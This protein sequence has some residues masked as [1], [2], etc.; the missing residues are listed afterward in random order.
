MQAPFSG[1]P[2]T[3][4]GWR[5]DHSYSRLPDIFYT[6]TRPVPVANPGLFVFNRPLAVSL[7]L[8][9][10][11]L[12]NAAAIFAGNDIPEGSEPIAQAYAGHQFGHFTNLGD[13]RAILLG[14]HITPGG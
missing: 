8:D 6:R 1:N 10:E 9:P 2:E 11:R 5:W 3:A 7:G 14:E 4:A 13:G 12:E